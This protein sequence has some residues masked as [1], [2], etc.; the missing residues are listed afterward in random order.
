[1][2]RLVSLHR[3]P[4]QST[5][6]IE[7]CPSISVTGV[8]Q[9]CGGEVCQ[10]VKSALAPVTATPTALGL[11]VY[12]LDVSA[13]DSWSETYTQNEPEAG[14]AIRDRSGSSRGLFTTSEVRDR[15]RLYFRGS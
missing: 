11:T 4:V 5:V 8:W 13:R 2:S 7:L 14:D 6:L 3:S 12:V 10:P 1:M 15:L 9:A